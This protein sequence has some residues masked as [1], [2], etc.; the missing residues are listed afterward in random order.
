MQL[1]HK[2]S[3]CALIIPAL[4]AGILTEH[5]LRYMYH[6]MLWMKFFANLTTVKEQEELTGS[7]W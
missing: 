1:F 4:E 7:V 3:V 2:L 5:G 6:V